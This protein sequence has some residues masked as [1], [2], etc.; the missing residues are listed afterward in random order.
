MRKRLSILLVLA[1]IFSLVACGK[2]PADDKTDKA[3]EKVENKAD[4]EKKE[5]KKEEAKAKG[6]IE[7]HGEGIF[8][9]PE[10]IEELSEER[11][12]EIYEYFDKN[13]EETQGM[14]YEEVEEY[15]GVPG[16]HFVDHDEENENGE[17]TKSIFWYS[18]DHFLS[19]VFTADKDSPDDFG[20][21]E[22]W[23]MP[24]AIDEDEVDPQSE[25][26]EKPTVAYSDETGMLEVTGGSQNIYPGDISKLSEEEL[27][28]IAKYFKDNYYETQGMTY[29]EVAEY[30]GVPGAHFEDYDEV[31]PKSGELTRYVCWYSE[32]SVFVAFFNADA[33]HP[34]DFGLGLTEYHEQFK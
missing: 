31:D 1:T 30:I 23:A 15:I 29:E 24:K 2:K 4:T 8:T 5:E 34:D 7:V 13:M 6:I 18:P 33:E 14:T 16:A 12:K 32:N 22:T 17:L 11:L 20:F 9:T 21:T 3:S 10:G 27:E 28:K 19:M 26:E 25:S